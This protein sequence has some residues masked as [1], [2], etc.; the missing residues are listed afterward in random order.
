MVVRWDPMEGQGGLYFTIPSSILLE[1][2]FSICVS[3]TVFTQFWLEKN[4]ESYK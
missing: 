4:S 2:K 3:R 1:V